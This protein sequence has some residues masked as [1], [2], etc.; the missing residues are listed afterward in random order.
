MTVT[1]WYQWETKVNIQHYRVYRN[2]VSIKNIWD[3]EYMECRDTCTWTSV[4]PHEV[5]S[6]HV[7]WRWTR[8]MK[9]N[10]YKW[11]IIYMYRASHVIYTII[12]IS[13][14]WYFN[15]SFPV[16][17]TTSSSYRS[18]YSSRTHPNITY[19]Y[20]YPNERVTK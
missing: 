4:S 17:H 3:G 19:G 18:S 11:T 1:W 6:I 9:Y 16:S 10:K 7:K 8:F 15:Q 5:Q 14:V 12:T 2:R 20:H 13:V